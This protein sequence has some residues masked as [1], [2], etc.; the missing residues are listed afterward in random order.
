MSYSKFSSKFAI[1]WLTVGFCF[2]ISCGKKGALAQQ[3]PEVFAEQSVFALG[4]RIGCW[5][6]VQVVKSRWQND[7]KVF[8]SAA[9]PSPYLK[10]HFNMLM[11]AESANSDLPLLG[12][13]ID[14]LLGSK[15]VHEKVGELPFFGKL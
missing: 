13:C 12:F 6:I 8:C 3:Q 5:L 11:T 1:N 10:R 4:W 14:P 15:H 2:L 9:T 7:K